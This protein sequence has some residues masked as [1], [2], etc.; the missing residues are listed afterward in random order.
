[1]DYPSHVCL[2]NQPPCRISHSGSSMSSMGLPCWTL[3]SIEG[4]NKDASECGPFFSF[5]PPASIPAVAPKQCTSALSS[6]RFRR[7]ARSYPPINC[8][9]N[10]VH[11]II[12]IL[13]WPC[14][15]FQAC[16][17]L[18]CSLPACQSSQASV[19]LLR[20]ARHTA[21]PPPLPPL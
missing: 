3:E 6:H 8:A 10:K 18:I 2:F 13:H 9:S 21:P 7:V 11:G 4:R 15:E 20:T 19:S 16:T 12:P 1:M 5:F 14:M 17:A